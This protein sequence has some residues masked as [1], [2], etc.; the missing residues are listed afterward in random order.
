MNDQSWR[1]LIIDPD[2]DRSTRLYRLLEEVRVREVQVERAACDEMALPMLADAVFDAV[3]VVDTPPKTSSL[4][5]IRKLA[6]AQ[7]GSP[8]PILLVA[9][10]A[11]Y[12][13][14][15][16]AMQAGASAYLVLNDLSGAG[17]ER[18]IR[19]AVR[20]A[21]Q[22]RSAGQTPHP[23]RAE[24]E[25]RNLTRSNSIGLRDREDLEEV[26]SGIT[27]AYVALDRNWRFIEVNA[28]ASHEFLDDRPASEVLGS[29]IWEDYPGTQGDIF[30]QMFTKAM[31]TGQP[32][33]FE[34]VSALNQKWY[35][36]HCYPRHD[37]LD[38]Y[39]RDITGRKL[40]EQERERLLDQIS[41]QA[42]LLE[43]QK[44]Q[45]EN[46]NQQLQGLFDHAPAGLAL[47]DAQPPYQVLESNLVYQHIWPQPFRDQ[48][49]VGHHLTDF[50]PDAEKS[51]IM[52]IFREVAQTGEGQTFYDF[53]F[54][55]L[56]SERG[57]TWWDWELSP[58]FEEDQLTSFVLIAIDMTEEVRA[59]QR[60]ERELIV[61]QQFE[62]ALLA[63]ENRLRRLIDS[64]I[65]GIFFADVDGH[66]TDANDAFL[67]TLGC[68]RQD[69]LEGRINWKEMTP[70]EY[71]ALDEKGIEEARQYGACMP[72]EKEYQRKDGRRLPVLS[73]YAH[74]EG[75]TTDF[76]CFLLDLTELKQAEAQARH[77]AGE[78]ERSNRD[79]QDFAFI[80]SH[81]LQE[82]L[83]KINAFGAR[84]QERYGQSLDEESLDY[85]DRMRAAAQ[86]MQQ[87]IDSL[88]TYSRVAT[89]ASPFVPVD[90]NKIAQD[91]VDDLEMRI[92][93]TG[94]SV[95]ISPLPVIEADPRQV[96]HLLQNLVGNALKFHKPGHPA[97]VKVSARP[98]GPGS[99]ELVVEDNGVGFDDAYLDRIFQPFQ[100]LHG[101]SEFEG[102]GM[103]LAICRKIVERH[104]GQISAT[105]RPGEG[106]TFVVRLPT[107]Q[108]SS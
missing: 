72:Y 68:T 71:A 97:R 73:G 50:I 46:R 99:I 81:D 15:L 33:H 51:G 56:L 59:R 34:A 57:R 32:Q 28:I 67:S 92:E 26:L 18:E 87:M 75:S 61:R 16:A 7:N 77:Y 14:D 53:P 94:G 6:A 35:E 83:R 40:A 2:E 52:A 27:D 107:R 90:L 60:L 101:R 78:L 9:D 31:E 91:A 82:P 49:L 104:G 79:L 23:A 44:R 88:L 63:S 89:Q 103:G 80:A 1:I 74:F 42:R 64:N 10:H 102:S 86:R 105:S 8:S 106:S 85:L 58:I 13:R 5:R 54:D 20:R 55:G 47:F 100:R 76:I 22:S 29:V 39:H 48:G 98:A 45:L 4:S 93:Q 70:P 41:R 69:L 37:R 25:H 30:Y 19:Y 12:A 108:H 17:L 95:E 21:G 66:V 62:T 84:L 36:I 3:L 38:I 24:D 11:D 65:I 43:V 96:Q